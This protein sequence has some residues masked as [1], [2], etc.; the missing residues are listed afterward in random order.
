MRGKCTNTHGS[1]TTV[2]GEEGDSAKAFP[3]PTSTSLSS[4]LS[5]TTTI[6][7]PELNVLLDRLI[8]MRDELVNLIEQRN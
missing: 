7:L 6:F 1:F 2:R 4:P 8:V 5:S 3:I